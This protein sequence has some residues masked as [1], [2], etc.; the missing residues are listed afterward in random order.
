MDSELLKEL[1][2]NRKAGFKDLV[3]PSAKTPMELFVERYL[4]HYLRFQ[5]PPFHR[6]IY[7]LLQN[8]DKYP[9]LLLTAPR[10]FGKSVLAILLDTM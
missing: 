5:T 6:E 2:R 8:R 4:G 10:Y 9:Q 1:E 7:W 3:V